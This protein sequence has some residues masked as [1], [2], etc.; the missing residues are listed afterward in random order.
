MVCTD[1]SRK[2]YRI[3]FEMSSTYEN[4]P[5]VEKL[6]QFSFLG[7]EPCLN[8]ALPQFVWLAREMFPTSE[9][10]LG[11][12]GFLLKRHPRLPVQPLRQDSRRFMQFVIEITYNEITHNIDTKEDGDASR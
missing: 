9:R 2:L 12:N 10:I 4:T 6:K 11:T 3:G 1:L 5:V 7:G 8:P